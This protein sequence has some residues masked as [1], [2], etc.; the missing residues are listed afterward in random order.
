MKL[1]ALSLAAAAA[2]F[3]AACGSKPQPEPVAQKETPK[4]VEYFHVDAATA[5]TVSGHITFKGAKPAPKK[6]AMD[7][8]PGCP[9]TGTYATVITG[10]TGGL[11]NAFVYIQSGLEGKQF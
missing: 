10:K 8:D 2:L 5:G 4:A 11:A 3:S 7:S 1:A 6:I 9:P